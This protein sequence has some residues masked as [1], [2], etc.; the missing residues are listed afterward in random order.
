MLA[1]PPWATIAI[2]LWFEDIASEAT[3]TV[4][5]PSVAQ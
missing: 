5:V 1:A 4:T 3:G 2:A